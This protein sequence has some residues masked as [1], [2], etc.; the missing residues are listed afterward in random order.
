MSLLDPRIR[1]VV[2]VLLIGG[3]VITPDSAFPAYP[4]LWA[5]LGSLAASSRISPWQLARQAGIVLPF[6][7]AAVSLPF[8]QASEPLITVV[9]LT[10]TETGVIRFGAVLLKSWLAAQV[11]LLLAK[12]TPFTDLLWALESL[13]VPA[14]LIAIIGF[15]YRYLFIH[16]EEAQ[17]LIRARAARSGAIPS[18]KAGGSA[19]WRAQVAG[20]MVGNLFLRS[21]E[22]SERVYAA[23]LA[24]GYKGQLRRLDPPPLAGSALLKGSLPVIALV[25]IQLMA[26]GW[27]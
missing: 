20:G 5:L 13:R 21:Y 25:A 2:A 16:Q 6:A 9:G 22:R 17:Q 24:R 10:I 19:V 3:I 4:L 15:M 27:A 18:R 8:T 23:M 14:V 1:V 26:R 12:T 7:L 11:G